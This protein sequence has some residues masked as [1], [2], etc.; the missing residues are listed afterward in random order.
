MNDGHIYPSYGG[1]VIVNDPARNALYAERPGETTLRASVWARGYRRSSLQVIR[2]PDGVFGTDDWM[3]TMRVMQNI[4]K[5]AISQDVV[6][7]HRRHKDSISAA[8]PMRYI[9]DMLKAVEKVAEEI[10]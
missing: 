6:Y 3:F 1:Y 5:Y 10:G 7:L 8:M 9:L 4:K 2:F